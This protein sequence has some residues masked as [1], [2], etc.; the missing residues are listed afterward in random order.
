VLVN[1][2]PYW[3]TL[4]SGVLIF[5]AVLLG[6]APAMPRR[7]TFLRAGGLRAGSRA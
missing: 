1:V 3:V 7:L 2:N 6:R 4:V 5:V